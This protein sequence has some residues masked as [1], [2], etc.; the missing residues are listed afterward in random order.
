MFGGNTRQFSPTYQFEAP[1]GPR[2]EDQN[3]K[4]CGTP[5]SK[6]D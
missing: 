4:N 1:L 3:V 6:T 2:V 5:D